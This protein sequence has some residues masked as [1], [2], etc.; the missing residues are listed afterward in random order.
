M[1]KIVKLISFFLFLIIS[2]LIV[3]TIDVFQNQK[4]TLFEKYNFKNISFDSEFYTRKQVINFI[5]LSKKYNIII[6]KN[7]YDNGNNNIFLNFDNIDDMKLFFSNYFKLDIKDSNYLST[8]N[9]DAIIIND[10]LK[11][12]KYNFYLYDELVNNNGYLFGNYK[13]FYKSIDELN[14]FYGEASLIGINREEI[15]SN[16]VTIPF[17][18]Q[19]VMLIILLLILILCL[20]YYVFQIYNIYN[21]S[22]KI[23]CM[24]LLGLNYCKIYKNIVLKDIWVEVLFIVF[25]SLLTFFLPNISFVIWF[26]LLLINI[27][28]LLLISYIDYICI[29]KISTS[30]NIASILKKQN[31][32]KKINN[33]SML[34]KIIFTT[35]ILICTL[36]FS[37]VINEVIDIYKMK[38]KVEPLLNYAVFASIGS[39]NST[40]FHLY[41]EFYKRI[42]ESKINNFYADFSK[43]DLSIDSLNNVIQEEEQ[44]L[45]Y[46]YASIDNN[47][48]HKNAVIIY[49]QNDNIVKNNLNHSFIF[50]KSKV[51]NI[52]S[53]LNYYKKYCKVDYDKYDY[54]F[55]FNVYIYDDTKLV[56]Y[57]LSDNIEYVDSPILRIITSDFPIPYLETPCGVNVA[58]TSINTSLKIDISAGKNEIYNKIEPIL[59]EL[60]LTKALGEDTFVSYRDY[61][62][63]NLESGTKLLVTFS[64]IYIIVLFVYVFILIQIIS[65]FIQEK[66][67]NIMV[68]KLLG[69]D[70]INIYKKLIIKNLIFTLISIV[71]GLLI[72]NILEKLDYQLFFII[73]FL[74]II[75]DT[76]IVLLLIKLKRIDFKMINKKVL[77]G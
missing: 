47:Y 74:F 57:R 16:I 35:S 7:S 53:F 23:G 38:K 52:N 45:Y 24:K 72:A 69:F 46:R 25:I 55:V 51:N 6:Y 71:L 64:L 28:I 20:F 10:F 63:D 31:I 40:K 54:P 60:G 26:I 37:N 41:N 43:Y 65:I 18:T 11:N 34:L 42:N 75:I 32:S 22:K 30:Y 73:S 61:L 4:Y 15:S 68:K 44:G 19:F 58:G 8:I 76:L 27:F 29:R 62:S 39:E 50:P 13:I 77:K 59:D 49:D 70:M 14:D 12:S 5:N 33:T 2:I 3:I 67:K 66:E 56:T 48:L 17:N 36:T 21:Q 1:K 9:S